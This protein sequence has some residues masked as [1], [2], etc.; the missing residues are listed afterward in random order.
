M[1]L[2][3]DAFGGVEMNSILEP[4]IFHQVIV[5]RAIIAPIKF[6]LC[7]GGGGTDQICR[8]YHNQMVPSLKE[9]SREMF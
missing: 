2:K 1:R 9:S 7:D 4:F 5:P 8:C 3:T 6:I